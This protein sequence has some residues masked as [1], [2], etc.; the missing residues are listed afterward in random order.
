MYVRNI[1]DAAVAVFVIVPMYESH[2]PLS[3]GVQ[4][5]ESLGRERRSILYG[6]KQRLG[7]GIVIT[8]ARTR[9]QSALV[10]LDGIAIHQTRTCK[11]PGESRIGCKRQ[12]I[13]TKH[14][15]L[16]ECHEFI[17]LYRIAQ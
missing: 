6:P 11:Y 13:S 9:C 1:S 7:E 8:H 10:D 16:A 2:C 5:C 4:V 14:V 17:P 15:Q 3:G 12:I